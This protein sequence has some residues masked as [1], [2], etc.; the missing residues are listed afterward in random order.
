M[1]DVE[2]TGIPGPVLTM[3]AYYGSVSWQ[4]FA[5]FIAAALVVATLPFATLFGQPSP[6]PALHLFYA[7]INESFAFALIVIGTKFSRHTRQLADRWVQN[8][9]RCRDQKNVPADYQTIINCIEQK[10]C[11]SEYTG[12]DYECWLIAISIFYVLVSVIFSVVLT[13]N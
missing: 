3:Y 12:R 1:K 10:K 13:L 9:D 6:K 7:I 4:I 2:N 11:C 5:I 8:Y